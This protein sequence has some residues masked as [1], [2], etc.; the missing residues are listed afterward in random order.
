MSALFSLVAHETLAPDGDFQP[1]FVIGAVFL[2]TFLLLTDSYMIMRTSWHLHGIDELKRGGLDISG[3]PWLKIRNGVFLAVRVLLSVA[4]SICAPFF[5][6]LLLFKAD[7][8]AA[9]TNQN[10]TENGGIITTVRART[11]ADIQRA[12]DAVTAE[13]AHVTALTNQIGLARQTA[14]D[15]TAGDPRLRAAEEEIR[16]LVAEKEKKR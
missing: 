9:M 16:Q 12:A 5:F 15:P 14:T 8:D 13:D 6:G 1:M 4:L 2:A 10:R 11:E 7:I 3:G